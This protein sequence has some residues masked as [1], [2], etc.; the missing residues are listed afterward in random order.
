M[1]KPTVHLHDE[2]NMEARNRL[3][4]IAILDG[5]NCIEVIAIFDG[6]ST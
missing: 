6:L 5:R 2:Q 4:V 1:G 3:E